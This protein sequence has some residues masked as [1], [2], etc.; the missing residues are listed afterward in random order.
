[1]QNEQQQLNS[2]AKISVMG[3]NLDYTGQIDNYVKTHRYNILN[4]IPLTLFEN[5]RIVANDYFLFI[6]VICCL[7][8]SP[9]E[10]VFQLIPLSFVL[11]VSMVKSGIEDYLKFREDQTKN[12]TQYFVYQNNNWEVTKSS[13]IRIGDLVKIKNDQMIPCDLLY[14]CSSN[15][16]GIC[17]YSEANLNGETAVKTMAD[18]PIFNKTDIINDPKSYDVW[19]IELNEPS[20]SLNSFY[21]RLI[22][23]EEKFSASINNILL[24]GMTLKYTD[25]VIGVAIAT[26]ADTRVMQNSRVPP[27]KLTAF[28]YSV[29]KAVILIFV[30]MLLIVVAISSSC[31][32]FEFAGSFNVIDDV[33]PSIGISFLQSILQYLI[34]FSYMIPISLM[35]IIEIL[36][37]WIAITIH[38]DQ[39]MHDDEMGDAVPHNSNMLIDMAKINFV[40]TDKTGTLTEN[41]MNLVS[42]VDH[43]GV[44][45]QYFSQFSAE[46]KEKSAD[47]LLSFVLNNS[48]IVYNSPNGIEY[49]A[50]SPDEAAFVKF[51]SEC[52]WVLKARN[53]ARIAIEVNGVYQVYDIIA[54]FPFNSTRKRMTVVVRKQG[55]EGLLVLTKGAD[56]II[57]PRCREVYF[58][59][60][61]NDYAISGYRTLVFAM[62]ELY[63]EEKQKFMENLNKITLSMD[64]VDE[65]LLEF[66]ESVEQDLEC[67]GITAIED[68]LQEGVPETIEW[69]RRAGIHVWVLTGDKLETAI[70]IGKTSK[71]IPHGSDVLILGNSDKI[72]TLLDLGRYI[73]EFDNF[74]DPVLVITE[75]VLEFCLSNQSYLFFKLAMK[76]KSVIFSR[77]SPYMKA[78]IVN[79]VRT[80]NNAITLAVGDGANDVGMIQESSVSVGIFGREGTQAAQMSDFAIPKF[81]HLQKLIGV[82]G[83]WTL[84]RLSYVTMMM[85]Y[86]NFAFECILIWCYFNN[87]ASPSSFFDGF[88][89]TCFNLIFS[90]IPVIVFGL[91]DKDN[92]SSDLIDH[93]ELHGTYKSP[94]E[95]SQLTYYLILGIVQSAIIYAILTFSCPDLSMI[96]TGT[97]NYVTLV[98]VISVQI[99]FWSNDWNVYAI[100]LDLLSVAIMFGVLPLYG[101]LIDSNFYGSVLEIYTRFDCWM[102]M[103]LASIISLSISFLVEFSLRI[104]KPSLCQLVHENE[105]SQAVSCDTS[106][107][108]PAL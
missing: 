81:R 38:V 52:N 6:L 26:G 61:L 10:W 77:V 73:D 32:A 56:N 31:V 4:F 67:I 84:H 47:M 55:E 105:N 30:L 22:K 74:N 104:L 63:G 93:P 25:W 45:S 51:A 99:A 71:V 68:K 101:Y 75:E 72:V 60:E 49:N 102:G 39:D 13:A 42:F 97:L 91:F 69:L 12:N 43:S 36:R 96:G 65:K 18:L 14:V 20:R 94:L 78:K 34:I 3:K 21:C 100:I 33:L 80:R 98:I 88:L 95:Y 57:Y 70:E 83:H 17:N 106:D 89:M 1:M 103:I 64:K 86:K 53:P 50:E 90:F 24:R 5:F 79:L 9:V 62:K 87:L 11:L 16:D 76:C 46:D 59:Q 85:L 48:V 44:H 82:H 7:P 28:D 66:A 15:N 37:F 27:A 19:N 107:M 54:V 23:G 35:V 40:L 92:R 108:D 8:Y 58:R 41:K 2:W 29:N